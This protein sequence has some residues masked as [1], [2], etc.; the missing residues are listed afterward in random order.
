LK[1]QDIRSH[2]AMDRYLALVREDCRR[3]VASGRALERCACPACESSAST[4]Q[5][6]KDGFEYATCDRCDTLFA[7]TRPAFDDLRTFY[8]D[9]TATRF[10]IDEFFRPFAETRREKIFRVRAEYVAQCF[11]LDPRWLV[12]DIGAGWGLFS[13]ELRARWPASRY[14]AIEPSPEQAELCRQAGLEVICA[15][16]EEV[17][18]HRG[19]FD[20]LVAFELIEH[21]HDPA[22]FMRAAARLLKPGGRLLLTSL[23]GQGF[24]I[25]ILWERSRNIYPPCH[26]NF[27][28]PDS[29]GLLL[30]RCGL[31]VE[32]ASTPGRLDWSIVEGMIEREPG[33][34]GRFWDLVARRTSESGKAELQ[35]WI[36][37]H[38][39]SS[40]MQVLARRDG[41]R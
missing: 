8:A 22:V 41:V 11:G 20:L 33:S 37:R 29:L 23:N 1:E 27:F 15:P 36:R 30:G 17:G 31:A 13:Q 2:E 32:E 6:T 28:N 34:A 24:D 38:H 10:W 5:F 39:L 40:H 12:G 21:L 16:L 4:L 7:R 35:D 3:L 25:Q 14:V 19:D 18:I 26:L 9:S